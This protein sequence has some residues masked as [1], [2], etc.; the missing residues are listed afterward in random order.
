MGVQY[1][2]LLQKFAGAKEAG[3]FNYSDSKLAIPDTVYPGLTALSGVNSVNPRLV[4]Y[5]TVGEISNFTVI[6]GAET[7]VG[8]S[9]KGE[10]L[11]IGLDP[12]INQ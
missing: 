11:I 7:Y 3:S 1:E 8:D 12:K 4:L 10:A 5:E 9:R 6:D 2:L